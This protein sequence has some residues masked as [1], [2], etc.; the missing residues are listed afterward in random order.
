MDYVDES[1]EIESKS[2]IGLFGISISSRVIYR[3]LSSIPNKIDVLLSLVGVVDMQYTL[4][5][6]SGID[7]VG[8][9]LKDPATRYG[10]RKLIK[11][12]VD[13]DN[14]LKILIDNE[15]HTIET[16]KADIDK[17]NTPTYLIVSEK[18]KWV[19]I[20]DYHKTF[21]DNEKILK[22]TYKISN[23]GHELYKNPQAAEYAFHAI[24]GAF[25]E[26]WGRNNTEVIKPN[27]AEIIEHNRKERAREFKYAKP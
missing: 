21:S 12:P 25:S 19:N 14:F 8:E 15:M 11:Y 13:W 1:D 17:I 6:I 3:Y 23:A 24:V 9:A 4:K 20:D 10:I 18:D 22:K 2:G 27:I 16:T 5:A 7:V 26:F